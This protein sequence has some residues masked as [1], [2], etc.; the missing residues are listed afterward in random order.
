[1]PIAAWS[2]ARGSNAELSNDLAVGDGAEEPLVVQFGL[3][4]IRRGKASDGVVEIRGFT[5]ICSD[6]ETVTRARVR[7]GQ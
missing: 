2:V 4:G 3:I 6:R 7:A 1:M 5:Q